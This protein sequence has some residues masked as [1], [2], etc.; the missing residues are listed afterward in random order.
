MIKPVPLA[1]VDQVRPLTMGDILDRIEGDADLSPARRRELRS[2][3]RRFLE[4]T[5]QPRQMPAD[6]VTVRRHLE[7]LSAGAAGLAAA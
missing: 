4:I 7:R 2:A 1:S 3:V 5:G 6:F